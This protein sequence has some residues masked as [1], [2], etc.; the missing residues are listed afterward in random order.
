MLMR[1]NNFFKIFIFIF[2]LIYLILGL[3][4]YKD[5]GITTDEEFQRYS[6]FYWLQYVLNYTPFENLKYIVGEK[7]L[8]IE[9]KAICTVSNTLNCEIELDHD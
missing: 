1:S 7:L 2:Y 5:F 3:L 6:G 4:I 8:L 9:A